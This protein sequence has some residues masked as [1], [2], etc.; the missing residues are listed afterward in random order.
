MAT[1]CGRVL[2]LV[3]G[4]VCSTLGFYWVV[5]DDT[6]HKDIVYAKTPLSVL[7]LHFLLGYFIF[8]IA[9]NIFFKTINHQ[10]WKHHIISIIVV[11]LSAYYE[12]VHYTVAASF[13][14]DI[15]F[16]MVAIENG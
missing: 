3:N 14:E 11:G 7:G 16:Q 10:F 6:L 4:I 8:D 13:L 12:K 1:W 9:F 5:L 15:D 2:Q